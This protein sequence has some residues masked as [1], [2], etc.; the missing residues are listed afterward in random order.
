MSRQIL[1]P[2]LQAYRT[3]LDGLLANIQQLAV[4]LNNSSLEQT[5]ESLR[6]NINEPFLF[7]VVGEV[8]AGKSSFVNSLL[9]AEVCA[10]DIE[11]C[12]DSIQ[13]I[14]YAEVPFT[15][16]LEPNLRKI[17][18]PIEILQDISIV[19]TPGTNTVIQE[20]QIVTE[21]YIPNSDLTF[22]VLF[23]KNPYQKSA[24][25]FLDFVSAEWRKKVVFILQQADLLR[26]QELEKNRE[27]VQ[28]YAH[29]KQIQSPVIFATSA[30]QEQAGQYD[31]SG[32]GPV[33]DYI[34]RMVSSG[35]SY[36]IKLRSLSSTSQKITET[37]AIDIQALQRQ[38]ELD[39][40][41]TQTIQQKIEAGR[42]RS[43]YEIDTLVERL[44]TRYGSI[45][46]R[47]KLEFRESLS[48]MTVVRRSFV[49][50]FNQE[51]SMQAWVSDFKERCEWE[52]R[53]SLE[54]ISQEGAQ[55]F[56]DGIR[57][58]LEGLTQDLNQLQAHQVNSSVISIKVLER[59]QEVIESVRCKVMNLLSDAGLVQTLSSGAESMAAEIVG[60]AFAAVVGTILNVVQFAV[61]EAFL[62]ALGIAF[63]GIGIVVFAVGIAWQRNQIIARFDQAL[64]GEK[65]RFRT[66]VTVRLA[67]KLGVIYEEV[68]RVFVSF[69]DYVERQEQAVAPVLQRYQE[70]E[71]SSQ[72]LFND[73]EQRL[74][75]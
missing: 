1:D 26:P 43:R 53:S 33:R 21:R 52:L 3:S 23:A 8:K 71:R 75:K 28:Q 31:S 17:G 47:I 30:E 20:H 15:E 41:V 24:W 62:N 27:R 14:V 66:D 19:D 32:F 65:D 69:Y 40:Q 73:L 10:T 67:E 34:R 18:L 22:F 35:D 9:G 46:D 25:D 58:L 48:V 6:R 13:Q 51:A 36:R 37:L 42:A 59:R 54:D 45:S 72:A 12:T 16:Q 7:V 29:Q 63:A 61:A 68:E 39:R 64:D 49:G 44:V 50:L 55:H 4:D 11:P 5:T 57:Q 74:G 56:V 60:G 70:I 2:K 38:L